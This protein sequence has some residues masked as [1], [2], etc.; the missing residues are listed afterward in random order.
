VTLY[1]QALAPI[2]TSYQVFT[3]LESGAGPVAQADGVPVCW[4]Y[5][6][7]RWRPGQIIADQ[8]AIYL[9]VEAAPGDY[10][11]QV[12]LYTADN[13]QRLDVLDAAGNPAGTSV[14]LTEVH[15]KAVP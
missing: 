15:L 13:F 11:L 4:S 1:W 10:P 14:T 12:G 3:H 8:H 5:P 7:D 9:P 2:P 6:T